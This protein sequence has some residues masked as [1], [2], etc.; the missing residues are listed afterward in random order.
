MRD[1]ITR[2]LLHKRTVGTRPNPREKVGIEPVLE[3][4]G[5][6]QAHVERPLLSLAVSSRALDSRPSAS[7]R[8]PPLLLELVVHS[9]WVAEPGH[10]RTMAEA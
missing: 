7:H 4:L 1:F 8:L 6:G 5:A 10:D 3:A 9:V 2:R